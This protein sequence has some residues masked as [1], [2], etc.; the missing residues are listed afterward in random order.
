M[1]RMNINLNTRLRVVF[2]GCI[3]RQ[4]STG[5]DVIIEGTGRKLVISLWCLDCLRSRKPPPI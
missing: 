5:N 1:L 4:L 3:S 2:Y